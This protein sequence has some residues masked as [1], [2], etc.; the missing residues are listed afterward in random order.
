[1]QRCNNIS[2]LILLILLPSFIIS[3]QKICE[4]IELKSL[5]AYDNNIIIE[6]DIIEFNPGEYFNIGIY[7]L[8]DKSKSHYPK[9][10]SGDIGKKIL[11]GLNR[12][13]IWDASKDYNEINFLLRPQ[14]IINGKKQG[15][16]LGGPKWAYLSLA[17]PGL[18]DYFVVDHKTT[19]IKPYFKTAAVLTLIG[20]GIKGLSER[21]TIEE[22]GFIDYEKIYSYEGY[23]W[24]Y[25]IDEDGNLIPIYASHDISKAWLFFGDYEV[26]FAAAATI[27]FLDIIYVAN[28]GKRNE[29][30]RKYFYDNGSLQLGYINH[31]PGFK[32]SYNF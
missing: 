29:E 28:R 13:I 25:A 5:G 30:A 31:R 26:F 24:K 16:Q 22:L 7:F 23:S 21:E 27:W 1:M 20:L 3:A 19:V 14:F 10:L 6:Y 8:D 18:G 12:K 15:A 4:N 17:V 32:F 2:F 9:S 11:G